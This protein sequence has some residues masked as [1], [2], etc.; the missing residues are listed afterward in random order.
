MGSRR[1]LWLHKGNITFKKEKTALLSDRLRITGTIRHKAWLHGVKAEKARS[2]IGKVWAWPGLLAPTER[3]QQSWD[4][5][6]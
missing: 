6:L 2:S 5:I 3:L 4:L 1:S